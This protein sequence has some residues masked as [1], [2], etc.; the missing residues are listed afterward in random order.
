MIDEIKKEHSELKLSKFITE[1][2]ERTMLKDI[3]EKKRK[4]R[5]S[6]VSEISTPPLSEF[7]TIRRRNA[8]VGSELQKQ[9]KRPLKQYRAISK[10][11]KRRNIED[12]M[13]HDLKLHPQFGTN[14][15]EVLDDPCKNAS[16]SSFASSVVSDFSLDDSL[17]DNTPKTTAGLDSPTSIRFEDQSNRLESFG[18]AK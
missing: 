16:F 12:T 15:Y 13:S 3:L 10:F 9:V 1:V 8:I 7:K 18:H 6:H 14:P 2:E 11:N 17:C 4:R 5:G